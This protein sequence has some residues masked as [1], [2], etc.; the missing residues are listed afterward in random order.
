MAVNA[1][2]DMHEVTGELTGGADLVTVLWDVR[3][4]M[5]RV[6]FKL[7]EE[8]L[9]VSAGQTRWLAD[10]NRELEHALDQLHRVEVLRALESAALAEQLSLAADATLSELA[11]R[12]S[13]PWATVLFEH[14]DAMLALA[15]EIATAVEDNRRLLDAGARMVRETLASITDSAGTYDARGVADTSGARLSR[16]DAQA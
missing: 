15:E 2:S 6:L 5:G 11:A 10:A 3:E 1:E 9:V 4:V 16:L 13:E 7:A 14:R 8:R 12:V